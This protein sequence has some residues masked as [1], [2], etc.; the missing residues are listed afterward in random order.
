VRKPSAIP[1]IFTIKANMDCYNLPLPVMNRY[2]KQVT[3]PKA[4]GDLESGEYSLNKSAK[5]KKNGCR[6]FVI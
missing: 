6:I 2:F 1:K 3:P 4:I 5:F